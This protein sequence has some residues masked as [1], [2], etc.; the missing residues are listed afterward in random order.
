MLD[1]HR[2]PIIAGT[3]IIGAIAL[4]LLVNQADAAVR[5]S[6]DDLAIA[7]AH[8]NDDLRDALHLCFRDFTIVDCD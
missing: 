6:R 7:Y 5:N 8:Y 1:D 2:G 3:A 4:G